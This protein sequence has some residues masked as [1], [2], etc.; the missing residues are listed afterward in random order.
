[1]RGLKYSALVIGLISGKLFADC[2]VVESARVINSSTV[3]TTSTCWSGS[4]VV[5]AKM[6]NGERIALG[7]LD[8]AITKVRLSQILHAQATGAPV[9]YSRNPSSVTV[10]AGTAYNLE[11]LTVGKS[12]CSGV[13]N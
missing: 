11:W 13:W 6:G 8:E 1:M 2:S 3:S 7:T 12:D 10:C 9:G 4:H 5:I